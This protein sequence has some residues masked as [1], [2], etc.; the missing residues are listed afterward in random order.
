M[1]RALYRTEKFS[2]SA[3]IYGVIADPVRHSIS[4]AVHIVLFKR[5]VWMQCICRFWCKGLS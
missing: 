1:L 3:K 4:P 2:H 5:T